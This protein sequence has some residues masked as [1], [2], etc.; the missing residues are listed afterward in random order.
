MTMLLQLLPRV[1][2]A[3]RP[4]LV[5]NRY[6]HTYSAEQQYRGQALGDTTALTR[7]R[8]ARKP[9]AA[10][11]SPAAAAACRLASRFAAAAWRRASS[12]SW[13]CSC[14]RCRSSCA[15]AAS[16]AAASA[17]A[18]TRLCSAFCSALRRSRKAL[19]CAWSAQCSVVW[20]VSQQ[21]R[22]RCDR[23]SNSN[24][25][26]NAAGSGTRPASDTMTYLST[27]VSAH[28]LHIHKTMFT[29]PHPNHKCC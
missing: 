26:T 14:A 29:L 21:P 9:R 18:V 10:A 22:S 17:A 5:V 25:Q 24:A 8:L 16:A 20:R 1:A 3:K 7:C 6:A 19:L 4:A 11:C 12:A 27:S 2:T 15:A 28:A 23:M 13:R